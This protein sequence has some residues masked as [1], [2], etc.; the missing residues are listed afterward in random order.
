MDKLIKEQFV[1]ISQEGFKNSGKI[2]NATC[3]IESGAEGT[4]VGGRDYLFLYLK[5]ENN[6]IIDIRYECNYCDPAMFVAAECLCN[7]ARGL[8]V[9][10]CCKINNK[11]FSNYLGDYS[12]MATE[13]FSRALKLL[14]GGI[15]KGMNDSHKQVENNKN[16]ML[17]T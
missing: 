8:K 14:L 12:E 17:I 9:D 3:V 7:L 4:C 16:Q 6:K 11:T 1:K 5:I 13:H 10:E 2:K 15:K